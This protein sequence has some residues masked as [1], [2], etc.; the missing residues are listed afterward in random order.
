LKNKIVWEHHGRNV[1]KIALK[2]YKLLE[3]QFEVLKLV[4]G[5]SND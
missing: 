1:S 2:V 5:V 4:E 3:K